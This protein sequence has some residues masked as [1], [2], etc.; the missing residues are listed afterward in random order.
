MKSI[1]KTFWFITLASLVL[2]V[3][4]LNQAKPAKSS[5]ENINKRSIQIELRF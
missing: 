1:E 5:P 2:L 4:L 3:I